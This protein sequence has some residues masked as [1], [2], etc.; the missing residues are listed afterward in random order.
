MRA[1]CRW[2]MARWTSPTPR[3]LLHHLDPDDAVVALRE[4]R[5]VARLGSSINDL[6]RGWIAFAMTAA[7]VL[8][9]SRGRVHAARRRPLRPPRVHRRRARRRSPR[10]AGCRSS[11]RSPRVLA[12]RDDG[13][14]M[15]ATALELRRAGGRRRA[16]RV[17]DGRG[18]GRARARRRAGSSRARIRGRRPAP[19]TPAR[20]SSRSCGASGWPT[21][22][23]SASAAARGHARH[24]RRRRG[25]HP[26]PRRRWA[27][28]GLGPG[29]D[30][31][32]TPPW[33]RHAVASGARLHG[34]H[35]P[36][37]DVGLARRTGGSA[38][39][40][41][42]PRCGR[43]GTR[44]MRCRWLIGAD[45]A[46]SR[47][48]QRD[49]RE[50]RR[51]GCRAGSAWWPTTRASR[52]FASHGEM[53]VGPGLVRRPRAAG[54]RPAQRRHGAADGRRRGGRPRSGS[55]PRSTASR[56]W[57]SGCRAGSG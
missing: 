35:A 23:G 50:A 40:R 49:R 33:P 52:S 22:P 26:L 54:R 8:A 2:P 45:G 56:P 34:A 38:A 29:A 3:M 51:H 24:P 53:H 6:R 20:G 1:P 18:A 43:G 41:C 14:P 44:G 42:R 31:T 47:V 17:R 55:R 16:G 36:S 4:M 28:P 46:R 57:P 48:S 11:S 25:R 39:A 32:S 12:A 21:T 13:V 30:A 9:L 15:T 7:A 10:E 27:A 19:S 37:S 5:R